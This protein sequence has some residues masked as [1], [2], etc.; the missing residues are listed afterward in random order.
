M[1]ILKEKNPFFC[2]ESEWLAIPRRDPTYKR[3]DVNSS[4][5]QRAFL[6]VTLKERKS[7]KTP[8]W[9]LRGQRLGV[10][11]YW[12]KY[13]AFDKQLC[14][15]S[16]PSKLSLLSDPAKCLSWDFSQGNALSETKCFMQKYINIIVIYNMWNSETVQIFVKKWLSKL[17]DL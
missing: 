9:S 8:W 16:R 2:L 17:W 7:M 15:I 6:P 12:N 5:D 1:N 4:N 11:C 10:S 3:Y 14:N 13:R